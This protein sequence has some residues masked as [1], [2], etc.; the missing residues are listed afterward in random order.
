E[1]PRS[2]VWSLALSRDGRLALAGCADHTARLW[3]VPGGKEV[4]RL[5][6]DGWV[7]A[8][9]LAP[10]GKQALT[11]ASAGTDQVI[12]AWDPANGQELRRY[13]EHRTPIGGLAFTA[14]GGKVLSGGSL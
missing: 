7:S 14:D 12:R 10:D 2:Y 3:D 8:V 11:A 13:T 9:A 5:K 4:A 1:S 6:H